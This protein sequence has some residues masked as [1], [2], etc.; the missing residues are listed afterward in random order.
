MELPK[1]DFGEPRPPSSN[2]VIAPNIPD[3]DVLFEEPRLESDATAAELKVDLDA[4][5]PP[6][7]LEDSLGGEISGEEPV[8]APAAETDFSD[9][10]MATPAA[11]A[12]PAPTPSEP[13]ITVT[14]PPV[15]HIEK[16]SPAPT[17]A[18]SVAP[19][20]A[21]VLSASDAALEATLRDALSRASR[22][23][24]ERIAWEVVPQL[25]EA[26]IRQE[27]DRLV[28]DRQGK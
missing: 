16:A 21:R 1:F 2:V 19:A 8:V 23:M 5:L 28:K 15:V 10:N 22:E 4:P 3:D 7:G 18:P 14:A 27:L 24:I 20:G 13:E 26:L 11:P 6:P 17:P 12:A 25:A 9:L